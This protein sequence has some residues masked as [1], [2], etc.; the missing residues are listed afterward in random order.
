M[1]NVENFNNQSIGEEILNAISHGIGALL[2]IAGTAVMIVHSAKTGRAIDVV[3]ASIY[4]FGLI[5]LYLMSTMYHSMQIRKAKR[6]FQKLDHCSI[7]VLIVGSYAPICLSLLGGKL[8]W[9]IFAVNL[10]LATLGIVANGINVARWS[11]ASLVL[12]LLMGWSIM[13]GIK[14]LL[15]LISFHAFLLLLFGGLF[16]SIG[17]IFYTSRKPRY[18]H[19]IW[20]LFVL[21][22]SICHY[23]F[24]LFFIL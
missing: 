12:Y 1:T 24:I 17:V 2:A 5:F 22:G 10:F 8:G 14:P 21:C 11:K 13:A 16:Y 19:G 7:F 23:F 6:V 9:T 3:S 15:H 18:M 4:C 20:H